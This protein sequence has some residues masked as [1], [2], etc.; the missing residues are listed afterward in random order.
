MTIFHLFFFFL[1]SPLSTYVQIVC[2]KPVWI[3]SVFTRQLCVDFVLKLLGVSSRKECE[4]SQL[5]AC[6]FNESLFQSFNDSQFDGLES[7]LFLVI[8]VSW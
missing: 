4:Q 3:Y 6:L 2:A 1:F 8:E 7:G 5:G